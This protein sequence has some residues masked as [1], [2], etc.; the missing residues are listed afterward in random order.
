MKNV[1]IV[2][3]FLLLPHFAQ[4]ET[5]VSCSKIAKIFNIFQISEASADPK[6]KSCHGPDDCTPQEVCNNVGCVPRFCA[7]NSDC[8]IGAPCN[9]GTCHYGE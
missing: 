8:A 7:K 3:A 1:L 6:Y 2:T 4:A 9:G 5:A